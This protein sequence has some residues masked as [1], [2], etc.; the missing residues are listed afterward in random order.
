MIYLFTVNI[1]K[2]K[3]DPLLLANNSHVYEF[4]NFSDV[5]NRSIYEI[6]LELF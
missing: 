6:I 1:K 3:C 4:L 2:K 5:V